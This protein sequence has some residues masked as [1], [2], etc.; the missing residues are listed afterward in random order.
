MLFLACAFVLTV[1][2]PGATAILATESGPPRAGGI[3]DASWR[4]WTGDVCSA[5][6]VISMLF[7]ARSLGAGASSSIVPARGGSSAPS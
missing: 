1:M 6:D 2:H 3:D 5:I 7:L 4:A